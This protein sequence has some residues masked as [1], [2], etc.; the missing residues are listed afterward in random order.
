MRGG[1]WRIYT[2]GYITAT[3]AV[4]EIIYSCNTSPI[5]EPSGEM[6]TVSQHVKRRI[7]EEKYNPAH[8]ITSHSID[9]IVINPTILNTID[10]EAVNHQHEEMR[11]Y[12]NYYF[13]KREEYSANHALWVAE[14]DSTLRALTYTI[15]RGARTKEEQYQLLLDFVTQEISYD[16]NYDHDDDTLRTAYSILK[17][18]RSDCSGRSIL[19]A[20]LVK[21]IDPDIFLVYYPTHIQVAISG[22][23]PNENNTRFH[24]NNKRYTLVET[25]MEKGRF[26]IGKTKV[27]RPNYFKDIEQIQRPYKNARPYDMRLKKELKFLPRSHNRK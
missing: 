19:Y 9:D 6:R 26:I 13:G 21:Q 16:T 22:D 15:T 1:F 23:F 18:K 2:I 4:S 12:N 24:V 8:A 20:S 14:K 25:S 27:Y 17:D 11:D 7:S 5:N 3:L 10:K